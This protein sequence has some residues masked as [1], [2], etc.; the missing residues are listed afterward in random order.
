MNLLTKSEK[1]RQEQSKA[2]ERVI[3]LNKLEELSEEQRTEL[4]TAVDRLEAIEPEIRAAVTAEAAERAAL[5]EE[6]R[7]DSDVD[8]ETRERNELAKQARLT[9]FLQCAIT[10]RRPSGPEAELRAAVGQG[11]ADIPLLMFDVPHRER[12]QA[13]TRAVT[14]AG[15]SVGITMGTVQPFIFAPSVASALGIEIRDVPSGT[16]AIPTITT[17]PSSAAPKAKAGVADSTAGALTVASATPKRIPARLSL[18][19]EDIAAVGTDSFEDSLRQALQGQ[20]SNSMDNQIINGDGNAP[21][22]NGIINQLGNPGAPAAA[23][24]TFDRWVS[25][26]AAVVDGLWAN[27]LQEISSIWNPDAYVQ[28]A[29]KFR[30]TDGDMTAASYLMEKTAGF[31]A[32]SRMPA[33]AAHIATGIAARLGQPGIARAV[34]PSWGRLTV[35][36]IYTDSGKGQRHITVSAIVGDLL[37]VQSSAY[38]Q[39]AARI[40]V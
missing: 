34:V 28:A 38:V 22:L 2:R 14:P 23:V 36:D 4:N 29:S 31:R 8:P 33:K 21:N 25:L 24:E 37:L 32:N 6:A 27:S 39:L 13:E 30:G 17:A 12:L 26:V 15:A 20:L 3:A 11:D 35:D 5:A 40:S 9:N 19:L 1:L 18:S 16:Y 10:G 7:T